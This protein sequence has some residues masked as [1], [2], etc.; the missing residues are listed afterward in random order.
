MKYQFIEDQRDTYA[1]RM[2]CGV[3]EV[4]ASGYYAWRGRS[5]SQRDQLDAQLTSQIVEI[6]ETSRGTYGRHRVRAELVERG[7][8]CGHNRVGRLM[9][10]AQLVARGR[11]M[12]RPRTTR[13]DHSLPVAPNLLDRDFSA[14][15][16]NQKWLADIT[17]IPTT[18]GWLY[19]AVVL[20]VFSRKIVGWSMQQRLTTPLVADALQ[21]ALARRSLADPLIH[22]SDRGS[23]YASAAYQSL[24]HQHDLLCSMSRP[25][26]CYDNAMMESFFATLKAE[27]P[28]TVFPSR[29]DA[30]Y[31]IFE[32]I[33]VWYN[34]QRR[35]SAL[36]YLSPDTFEQQYCL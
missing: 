36:D 28:V 27:L 5:P 33:E 7:H 18:D 1:V 21:D 24:L 8:E 2:L 3:L 35:H 15:A 14:T 4:S 6:F 34:R 32:F 22:H 23:Q 29:D 10:Q 31:H 26:N 12:R 19:L 17:Y 13:S 25:A 16:P 9:R 11:R 30:R 20:D